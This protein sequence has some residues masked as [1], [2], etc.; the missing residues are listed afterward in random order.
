MVD[1]LRAVA[2]RIGMVAIL[3]LLLLGFTIAAGLGAALQNAPGLALRV[4]PWNARAAGRLSQQILSQDT[5][6]GARAQMFAHSALARDPT[7]VSAVVATGLL[8]DLK[9]NRA[10]ALQ[11]FTY[12]EW[13]SRRD[14]GTQL[15]WVEHAVAAG[16]IDRAL[17]HY[18]TALRSS[19]AAPDLLFPTLGK[20]IAQPQVAQK[21]AVLLRRGAPWQG[22]F[23]EWLVTN[24]VNNRPAVFIM[25][26]MRNAGV[27]IAPDLF[28]RLEQGLIDQKDYAAAWN[29]YQQRHPAARRD[30][31]Q[32]VGF[33]ASPSG[34]QSPFD[35]KLASEEGG[36][37]FG[38]SDGRNVLTFSNVTTNAAILARQFML[39]SSGQYRLAADV[40]IES[41]SRDNLPYWSLRCI[42]GRVLGR[43]PVNVGTSAMWTVPSDCS[44]QWLALQSDASDSSE[45]VTGIVRGVRLT[46]R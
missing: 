16:D 2:S 19:Q 1:V 44:A 40:R 5:A 36:A 25:S 4:A 41:D 11:R 6:Q 39:L 22:Q 30:A 18:D 12:A 38:M 14:I 23:L 29:F 33:T 31:A 8:I 24:G 13:L 20:A 45:A 35:W 15:W 10:A 37:S 17:H 46:K 43:S 3:L 26:D 34:Q 9:G 32:D 28:G 27:P 21:L 7:V 42:D